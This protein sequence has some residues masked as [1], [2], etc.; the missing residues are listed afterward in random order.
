VS[1]VVSAMVTLSAGRIQ[2]VGEIFRLLLR[3]RKSVLV[4]LHIGSLAYAHHPEFTFEICPPTLVL[5]K[6]QY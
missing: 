5:Q 2:I 4:W 6:L 3:S 1:T